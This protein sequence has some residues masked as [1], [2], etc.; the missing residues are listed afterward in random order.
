MFLGVMLYLE[1]SEARGFCSIV[2]VSVFLGFR[3]Y[4]LV[5]RVPKL[6]RERLCLHPSASS[7]APIMVLMEMY[8]LPRAYAPNPTL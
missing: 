3:V 2:Q 5:L 6:R 7:H 8:Q 4:G 1:Y